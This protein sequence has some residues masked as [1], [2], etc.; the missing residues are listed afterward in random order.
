MYFA[1]CNRQTMGKKFVSFFLFGLPNYGL[2]FS[3]CL[4]ASPQGKSKKKK[5]EI[6]ETSLATR[7]VNS[8]SDR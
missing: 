6:K 3:F 7:M 2:S 5:Q 4:G 8:T 1:S